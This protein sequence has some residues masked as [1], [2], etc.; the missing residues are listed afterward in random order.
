MFC[1][2]CGAQLA[3]RTAFCTKCG[4]KVLRA[5][6]RPADAPGVMVTPNICYCADGAYRWYYEFSL[7][8]NP[9]ILFSVFKVLGLTVAILFVILSVIWLKDGVDEWVEMMSGA[10]LIF[11]IVIGVIFVLSIISYLIFA[12][13]NGGKYVVLFEMTDTYIRHIQEPRQFKKAQAIGWLNM[14]LGATQGNL[15]QIGQGM[16]MAS[17]NEMQSD[18]S[19]VRSV[20]ARRRGN[21][22]YVNETLLKNQVYAEDVDFD[23]V[24]NFIIPRCTKARI[25]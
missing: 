11:G 17:T 10:G 7:L 14:F 15:A 18:F 12:A 8:R 23:F 20:K 9:R 3:E 19:A 2:N 1:Q 21:I 4:A 13:I 6:P 22:I 16:V 24:A 5:N 25:K